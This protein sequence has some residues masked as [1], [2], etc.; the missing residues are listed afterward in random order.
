[1]RSKKS[2]FFLILVVIGIGF[3][4]AYYFWPKNK[5][6][7]IQDFDFKK[8]SAKVEALFHKGDN[9]YW[10]IGSGSAY[11]LDHMLRY[12]SSSQYEKKYDMVL[13]V[14]KVGDNIAGFLGYFPH[15]AHVWQLLFLMVDQDFR[16]QGIAKKLLK[17]AVDDMVAR[18]A[19]K[20]RLDTRDNNFK[21]QNLYKNFGF[22]LTGSDNGF[23]HFSW[24]KQ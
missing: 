13:K 10:M 7:E 23:V 20:V 3:G 16:R 4:T 15:S 18:G 5:A 1:M 22:K 19:I 14:L 6:V 24:Y 21:A 9:Y 12:K 11:S 17:F 8:D 2:I